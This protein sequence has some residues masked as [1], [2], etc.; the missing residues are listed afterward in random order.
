MAVIVVTALWIHTDGNVGGGLALAL[1]ECG[2][3]WA[4]NGW[5]NAGVVNLTVGFV[6]Q[7]DVARYVS[8]DTK[9][10]RKIFSNSEKI[11]VTLF[12]VIV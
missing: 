9:C 3:V 4:W 1:P 10:L 12:G 8:Y 11:T 6:P 5:G 2:M 7:A